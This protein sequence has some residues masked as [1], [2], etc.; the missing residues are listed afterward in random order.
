MWARRCGAP[1]TCPS[2]IK[3]FLFSIGTGAV[4][5][6]I[7]TFMASSNLGY[8]DL[9]EPRP[10]AVL[11]LERWPRRNEIATWFDQQ[12]WKSWLEYQ[13][14]VEPFL[15]RY[16]CH[17]PS[18]ENT[19]CAS[20]SIPFGNLSRRLGVPLDIRQ[21]VADDIF[22]FDVI[23]R[24]ILGIYANLFLILSIC[25][26]V[27]INV[28]DQALL[29]TVRK[30]YILDLLALRK[31]F[32]RCTR[33]CSLL[34]AW[35]LHRRMLASGKS[36]V[37]F[38]RVLCVVVIAPAV[39]VWRFLVFMFVVCPL[40]GFIFLFHPIRTSR[41]WILLVC[42]ASGVYGVCL[43]L[44]MFFYV[45]WPVARPRYAVMWDAE[46]SFVPG[47]D[48]SS[49]CV[50]SCSYRVSLTT[51]GRLM[52]IGLLAT[53]KAFTLAF[54][55]L[56]GLRRSNWANLMSVTFAVPVNAY[57][58]EWRQPDG[59]PIKGRGPF[60]PVQSELAFDPFAMMD[61][62]P[63]SMNS[64][65]TLVPSS[66]LRQ[67][68]DEES[69]TVTW[70]RLSSRQ[71]QGPSLTASE[72]MEIRSF[73]YIG[74]CGFPY[75]TGGLQGRFAVSAPEP[76]LPSAEFT[77]HD[78]VRAGDEPSAAPA[79]VVSSPPP[80]TVT[81]VSGDDAAL[82]GAT[83][84]AP[85]GDVASAVAVAT[86]AADLASVGPP[87]ASV[88]GQQLVAHSTPEMEGSSPTPVQLESLA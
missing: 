11:C 63:E 2:R 1:A 80:P 3:V 37:W 46:A 75:R 55:T 64:H 88:S 33:A 44:H 60:D 28:H 42:L 57:S 69:G 41:I 79:A 51:C 83:S 67:E 30:D 56:K 54:R 4:G 24:D 66:V 81:W 16:A 10:G 70:R 12:S 23:S 58:V 77:A 6:A 38:A 53:V 65:V 59:R 31:S 19:T 78:R 25:L 26:W 15:N 50:C 49:S 29:H 72:M 87:G 17:V 82:L 48:T 47:L 61:E 39:L 45:A 62:Q 14:G 21:A 52:M 27:A 22:D 84:P 40:A 20:V 76:P 5:V 73:E 36:F 71:L 7:Y 13:Q 74:W 9:S 34:M 8:L 35:R 68:V 32:P 85:G 43:T 86:S 18:V